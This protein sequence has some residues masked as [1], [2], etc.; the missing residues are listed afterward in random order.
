VR[1]T[2]ALLLLVAGCSSSPSAPRP[3]VAAA[4]PV[5]VVP[6]Y[7]SDAGS[8]SVLVS[9]LRAA[10][11]EVRVVVTPGGGRARMAAGAAALDREVRASGAAA[12][13]VVGFSAG[14]LVVRTWV[15]LSGGAARARHVVTL[16]APHHGSRA[17]LHVACADGC[18]DLLPGSALLRRLPRALPA[19]PG[20]VAFW[21][22]DDESVTPPSSS[23]LDGARNVRVQDV[24]PGRHVAHLDMVGDTAVVAMAVA[25]LRDGTAATLRCS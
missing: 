19:G 17:L 13:D 20:Y 14:G 10:G 6:G 22:A 24:C 21:T 5:F 23:M 12:V 4:P 3:P 11:R 9:A 15:T 16:S 7:A 18:V 25:A 2:A 8:V 1:R